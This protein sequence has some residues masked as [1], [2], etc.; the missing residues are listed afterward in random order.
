MSENKDTLRCISDKFLI[1]IQSPLREEAQ[2]EVSDTHVDGGKILQR[3]EGKVFDASP[4]KFR[5]FKIAHSVC[6]TLVIQRIQ[7]VVGR[8]VSK[9]FEKRPL[10]AQNFSPS[11]SCL[12]E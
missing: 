1:R 8:G 2:T 6:S 5:F 9:C 12:R 3:L 4:H 11:L 7:N 10:L